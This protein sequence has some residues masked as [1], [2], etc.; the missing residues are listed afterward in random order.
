MYNILFT[1]QDNLKKKTA[2]IITKKY[3]CIDF[4]NYTTF[5]KI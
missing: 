5:L 4:F 2:L 3:L 1:K